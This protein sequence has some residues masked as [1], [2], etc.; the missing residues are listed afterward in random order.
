MASSDELLISRSST[1]LSRRAFAASSFIA[2]NALC[3]L[4]GLTGLVA[5][6]DGRPENIVVGDNGTETM[7]SAREPVL[8]IRFSVCKGLGNNAAGSL[9]GDAFRSA[10]ES[11]EERLALLL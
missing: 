3:P 4:L 11:M 7:L 9:A 1:F 2:S 8:T 5:P 6:G 10:T